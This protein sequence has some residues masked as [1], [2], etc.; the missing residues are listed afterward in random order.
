M[1][2]SKFCGF[3]FRGSIF[4]IG[5][6]RI[7]H[8]KCKLQSVNYKMKDAESGERK[9]EVKRKIKDLK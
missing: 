8:E 1:I 5:D 7:N 6:Q 9:V 3:L 2:H 4:K